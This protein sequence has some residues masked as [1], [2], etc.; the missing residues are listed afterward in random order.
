MQV[1]IVT[2]RYV[3][4]DEKGAITKISREKD[5]DS[6]AIQVPFSKVKK[7]ME[8][9]ESLVEYIVEWDFL[10]KKHVLKHMSEWRTEQLKDNF[11]YEIQNDENADAVIQQDKQNKC[12]RLILSDEVL[13]AKVDPTKQFYSITKKYDPNVLYRLI[14]FEKVGNEYIVPFELDFEVD[15]LDLSIYTVRKFS[16][17][18]YEVIDG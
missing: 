5:Q 15:N 14:R 6:D 3:H 17:Y 13:E 18:S 12:W 2:S 10:E 7:L 8:G 16:T 9:R 4:Y 1:E 11:L